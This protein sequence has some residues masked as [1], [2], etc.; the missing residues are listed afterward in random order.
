MGHHESRQLVFDEVDFQVPILIGEQFDQ[1]EPTIQNLSRLTQTSLLPIGAHIIFNSGHYNSV[2]F[3]RY[4]SNHLKLN[5][6][7]VIREEGKMD[8]YLL[9]V[10][11]RGGTFEGSLRFSN[12]RIGNVSILGGTFEQPVVF[13]RG[14]FGFVRIKGGEFKKGIY[15]GKIDLFPGETTFFPP[16][17]NARHWKSEKNGIYDSLEIISEDKFSV[18]MSTLLVQNDLTIDARN[19]E[20]I[21][22]NIQVSRNTKFV[23]GSIAENGS[24]YN[25]LEVG[26]ISSVNKLQLTMA[27]TRLNRSVFSGILSR[28]SGISTTAM[29]LL[30]LQFQ[31]FVNQ[32][33]VVWDGPSFTNSKI[34]LTTN[35]HPAAQAFNRAD[36]YTATFRDG[37][38]GGGNLRHIH[39]AYA[40]ALL[41]VAPHSETSEQSVLEIANSDLGKMTFIQTTFNV[42]VSFENSKLNELSLLASEFPTDSWSSDT[43]HTQR[44]LALFQLKKAYEASGDSQKARTLRADELEAYR[45]ELQSTT[46][47]EEKITL[48]LNRTSNNY[49]ESWSKA[50]WILLGLGA[51]IWLLVSIQFFDIGYVPNESFEIFLQSIAYMIEFS[52]PVHR[53]GFIEEYAEKVAGF[54]KEATIP[55]IPLAIGNLADVLWRIVAAYLIYQMVAAFRKHGS[56]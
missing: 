20:S 10:E 54:R 22:S 9:S 24:Q 26:K 47:T 30:S 23:N 5:E 27:S 44:R 25:E 35:E 55:V 33:N 19:A 53:L 14:L 3:R 18:E 38:G 40:A 52:N 37:L 48:F 7:A 42:D 51:A 21:I 50:A 29:K 16:P 31:G 2:H 41:D 46:Q 1:R 12:S 13:E 45:Q 15:F 28:D 56:K 4:K 34:Q 43:N 32:S 49:G 8:E 11:I 6:G 17:E 39:E 36:Y